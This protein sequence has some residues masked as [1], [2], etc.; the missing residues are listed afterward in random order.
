M[1]I[2]EESQHSK[3]KFTSK[4]NLNHIKGTDSTIAVYGGAA[5]VLAQIRQNQTGSQNRAPSRRKTDAHAHQ[6]HPHAKERNLS[7]H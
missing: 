7:R 6:R 4:F 3:K 5:F 2:S 1:G